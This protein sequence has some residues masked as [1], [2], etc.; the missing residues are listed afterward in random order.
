M[1]KPGYIIAKIARYASVGTLFAAALLLILWPLVQRLFPINDPTQLYGLSVALL[2]ALIL[3]L[4]KRVV[5]SEPG[6]SLAIRR[7]SIG[8]AIQAATEHRKEVK[9]LRVLASTTE[10]ILPALRDSQIRMKSCKVM[11]RKFSQNDPLMASQ[12][13]KADSLVQTWSELPQ[14]KVAHDCSKHQC[15]SLP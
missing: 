1:R 6:E 15:C 4:A 3:D 14:R 5:P 11:V 7:L 13:A 2:A 10:T 9:V 8:A 12:I